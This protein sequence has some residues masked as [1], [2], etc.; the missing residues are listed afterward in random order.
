MKREKEQG[1]ERGQLSPCGIIHA[2][3]FQHSSLPS[4]QKD[5]AEK[6]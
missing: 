4:M 6:V 3:R 1:Q 2:D 5:A